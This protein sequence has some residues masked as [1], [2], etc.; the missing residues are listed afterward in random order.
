V[1]SEKRKFDKWK[2]ASGSRVIV[3]KSEE[4]L[5]ESYRIGSMRKCKRIER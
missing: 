1:G 3:K 5:K 2:R 4:T